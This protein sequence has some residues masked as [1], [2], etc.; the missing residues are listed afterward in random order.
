MSGNSD[1]F[2]GFG[3]VAEAN[4]FILG[5]TDYHLAA[6]MN[7]GRSLNLEHVSPS[8]LKRPEISRRL[9]SAMA[10][11]A[12][13]LA[14]IRQWFFARKPDAGYDL[15]AFLATLLQVKVFDQWL[16]TRDELRCPVGVGA[17]APTPVVEHYRLP[18][19]MAEGG[20]SAF[21]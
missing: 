6:L 19:L 2:E 7:Q 14:R 18:G 3:T 9:A 17:T 15:M 20:D 13:T 1:P 8:C 10:E 21:A 16:E 4:F 11:E 5:S 12:T